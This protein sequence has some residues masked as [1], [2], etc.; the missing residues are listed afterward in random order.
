MHKQKGKSLT[1]V[2][3]LGCR[4]GSLPRIDIP[5][6][7]IPKLFFDAGRRL[8]S[9]VSMMLLYITTIFVV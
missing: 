5:L 4:A 9:V 3:V 2:W 8:Q 6:F 7:P 1:I